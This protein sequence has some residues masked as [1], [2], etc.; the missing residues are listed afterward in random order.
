MTREGQ[1]IYTIGYGNRD[2]DR[3]MALLRQYG[4][5]YLI[6]IRSKPY[7]RY[8]QP[9]SKAPLEGALNKQGFKYVFMGDTLGGIPD[10]ESCYTNGKVDY[11]KVG[12]YGPYREGILRLKAAWEKQLVVALMCSERKPQECH[13]SKLI[14]ETL[15][16]MQIPVQHIDEEGNLKSQQEVIALLTKGQMPLPLFE[17]PFT[18]NKKYQDDSPE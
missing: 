10:D 5:E 14:G 2:L 18:S 11:K 15:A 12:Q 9:F 17:K 13:R 16:R 8:N 1:A 7:S 6:D 3:F 4:I